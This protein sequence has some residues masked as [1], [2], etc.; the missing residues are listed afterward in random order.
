[1]RILPWKYQYC[2]VANIYF[3]HR[4]YRNA[5]DFLPVSPSHRRVTFIR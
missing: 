2:N 4:S 3:D 1:M 5:E